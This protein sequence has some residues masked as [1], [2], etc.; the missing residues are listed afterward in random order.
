MKNSLDNIDPTASEQATQ[1]LSD[2]GAMSTEEWNQAGIIVDQLRK[3][4][5]INQSEEYIQSFINESEF[6]RVKREQIEEFKDKKL[7]DVVD[8]WLLS[9]KTSTY[10]TYRYAIKDLIS[11]NL[12]PTTDSNGNPVKLGHFYYWPHEQILDKI[13]NLDR[14]TLPIEADRIEEDL[15][16]ESYRQVRAA[17]Y[18]SFT[19]WLHRTTS[20][21][22][23]KAIPNTQSSPT[24]YNINDKCKTNALTLPQWYNFI[25]ALGKINHRDALIAKALLQGAKRISEVISVTLDKIDWDKNIIKFRQSKNG[26]TDKYIPINFPQGFMKELKEYVDKTANHRKD[27]NYVF[28]TNKGN[29]VTRLRLNYSFKKASEKIK[30]KKVTPHVLRATWVTFAKSQNVQDSEIM[31]VTGHT[32]S[33]FVYAYDKTSLEDNLTKKFMLV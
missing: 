32:S 12:I 26:G 18:I 28:V 8:E 7:A 23:R 17:A 19:A 14:S 10:E 30:I 5:R 25:D 24:F 33:R 31:K 2:L 9:I 4:G 22:F 16:R 29:M 21:W 13:K 15:Q 6:Q 3:E 1:P 27:S 20:G 11:K